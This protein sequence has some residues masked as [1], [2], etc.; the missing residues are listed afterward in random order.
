MSAEASALKGDV[1]KPTTRSL[2]TLVLLLITLSVAPAGTSAPGT[3][4]PGDVVVDSGQLLAAS[5]EPVCSNES[6]DFLVEPHC[7]APGAGAACRD[8]CREQGP[9]CKGTIGCRAGECVCTCNCP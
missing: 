8:L 4:V 5:E 2:G 7:C 9:G 3:T 1:M 6:L